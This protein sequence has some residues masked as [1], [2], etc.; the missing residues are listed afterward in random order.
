M[1]KYIYHTKN[2][3]F[4]FLPENFISLLPIKVG[5]SDF[6]RKNFCY[7]IDPPLDTYKI[8][9]YKGGY[10]RGVYGRGWS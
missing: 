6:F 1:Y 3:I 9:L 5:F 4:N 8:P 7:G 2:P 10:G